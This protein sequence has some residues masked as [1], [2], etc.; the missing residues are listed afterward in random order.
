M[1]IPVPMPEF[2]IGRDAQCHLR[3][4]TTKASRLHCA[5]LTREDDVFVRDLDS[6]NGTFVNG[7]RIEGEVRV[8]DG[9][10]LQIGSLIFHLAM[11]T[12][13]PQ[14]D[15]DSAWVVDS[16][17]SLGIKERLQ[18]SEGAKTP[19]EGIPKTKLMGELDEETLRDQETQ[20]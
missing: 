18:A 16:Q 8:R 4:A 7:N 5:I 6:T 15:S 14:S 9:D 12:D 3:P 13:V 20:E 1:E 17:S 10:S 11:Q 2:L 19:P